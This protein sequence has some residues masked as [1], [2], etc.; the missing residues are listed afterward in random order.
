MAEVGNDALQILC[1]KCDTF[2]CRCDWI[3]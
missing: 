3:V 2:C 1:M